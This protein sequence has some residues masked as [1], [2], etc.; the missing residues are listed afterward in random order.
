MAIV[1]AHVCSCVRVCK[2]WCTFKVGWWFVLTQWSKWSFC[3]ISHTWNVA[4]K[5]NVPCIWCED[6]TYDWHE[7][8]I[9][10]MCLCKGEWWRLRCDHFCNQA[11]GSWNIVRKSVLKSTQK[12]NRFVDEFS[13]NW[14]LRI[15]NT[16]HSCPSGQ[17]AWLEIRYG[18]PCVGSNPTECDTFFFSF[19]QKQNQQ[20][21]TTCHVPSPVHV[22]PVL[23][24][25][26]DR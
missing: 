25:G 13:H 16:E 9:A 19:P 2:L 1:C 17:G 8:I 10:A 15:P 6:N 22:P 5:N 26:D 23:S 24:T 3:S 12:P 21:P 20:N 4:E 18:K 7:C 14:P 11:N